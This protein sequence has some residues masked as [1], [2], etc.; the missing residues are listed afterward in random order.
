MN[1]V[2]RRSRTRAFTLIEA[3]VTTVIV[4]VGFVATL[5]LLASGAMATREGAELATAQNLAGNVREAMARVAFADPSQPTHWGPEAGESTAAQFDDVDDFD[6]WTSPGTP[7]DGC[8]TPLGSDFA[9]WTQAVAVTTVSADSVGVALPHGTA[10]PAAR[11]LSRV[12]VSVS[13]HG[14]AVYSESWLVGYAN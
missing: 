2:R 11:P 14:K 10:A 4:G 7:I 9:G 12:T 3:A 6:G 1:N 13:R 8:A 5:E